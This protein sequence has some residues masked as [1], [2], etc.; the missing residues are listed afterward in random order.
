M[1]TQAQI[2]ANCRNAELSPGPTSP[3]GKAT[4]SKNALK[5]GLTGRTI[6]LP[7]DDADAY[8][9]HCANF[10]VRFEPVG[11]AETNL[12]QALADTEWRLNRIPS[13]EAGIYALGRIECAE[14]FSDIPDAAERKLLIEAKIT[15]LYRRDLTNLRIQENRLRC[16]REKD[17]AALK[18]LQSH[19]SEQ[20]NYHE[21]VRNKK[22]DALAWHYAEFY[23]KERE[24]E[25]DASEFGSE[26]STETIAA[27]F[28][29]IGKYTIDQRKDPKVLDHLRQEERLRREREKGSS[30][31]VIAA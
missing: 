23:A 18:E 16:H 13:L 25:F 10:R 27:R 11:D 20:M 30:A 24:G 4:C 28:F 15:I 6:L 12:V 29:K 21:K 9:N 31:E 7:S 1:A 14:L 2:E 26:F 22:L 3:A 19:R 8:A 17:T 5:T